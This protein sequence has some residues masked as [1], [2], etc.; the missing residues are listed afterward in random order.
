MR[1]APHVVPEASCSWDDF[2]DAGLD[3]IAFP[4]SLPDEPPA[5]L[6]G[7][8]GPEHARPAEHAVPA[9][10]AGPAEHA[11]PAE[12]SQPVNATFDMFSLPDPLDSDLA[13]LDLGEE[14]AEQG[15]FKPRGMQGEVAEHDAGQQQD[16]SVFEANETPAVMDQLPVPQQSMCTLLM[17]EVRHL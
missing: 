3:D 14:E 9:D 7:L 12:H 5:N 11:E 2:H 10:H 15:Q 1:E 6:A 17:A 8:E 13:L 16:S 4:D